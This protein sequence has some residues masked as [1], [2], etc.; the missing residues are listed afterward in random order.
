MD[1]DSFKDINDT[2]G[3]HVGDRALREVADGPARRHP[4]VRHLRPLRRR[5]IHRRAV[6]VRRRRGGAEA[7]G[8]ADRRWISCSSKRGPARRCRS[9]SASARRSSRTT[10]IRTRRCSRRPTAACIA[11]R[12]GASVARQNPA[13]GTGAPGD[14]TASRLRRAAPHRT[15][16]LSGSVDVIATP[17]TRTSICSE[18][19]RHLERLLHPVRA[20]ARQPRPEQRQPRRAG[21]ERARLPSTTTSHDRRIRPRPTAPRAPAPSGHRQPD[22]GESRRSSAPRTRRSDMASS[23]ARRTATTPPVMWK[24]A[25]TIRISPVM[26]RDAELRRNIAASATS[27]SSTLRRS[28]VRSR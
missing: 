5:R 7:A 28:G 18:R 17:A 11:T 16:S 22:A 3:H 14:P 27:S 15:A 12:R 1:L 26:P 20:R 9:R 6:G 24:P 4:A 13:S 8:A 23:R 21:D 19:L 25:S 10:A 2:Y